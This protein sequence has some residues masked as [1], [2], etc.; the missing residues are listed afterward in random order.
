M[1]EFI[2]HGAADTLPVIPLVFAPISSIELDSGV[3]Q[4][5]LTQFPDDTLKAAA[6]GKFHYYGDWLSSLHYMVV[7][8]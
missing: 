5:S 8:I 6:L 7:L 4:V 2:L 3:H 1:C